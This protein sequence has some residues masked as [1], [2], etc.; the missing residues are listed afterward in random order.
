VRPEQVKEDATAVFQRIHPDDIEQV[1]ASIAVSARDITRWQDDYRVV[2][3]QQGLHWRSGNARPQRLPDGSTLWHGFIEDSTA[4]KEMEQVQHRSNQLLQRSVTG[5]F[6]IISRIMDQRDP[7]TS[8]HQ[9]RAGQIARLIGQDMGLDRQ[10]QEMLELTGLV[11]DVGKI[12]V[13]TEILTKPTRLTDIELQIVQSHASAGYEIL[14]GTNLPRVI[15]DA[16]HQHHERL[17]G[18]GYPQGLKGSEITLEARIIAV[19]DVLESMSSH[20]PYRP[21][22][23]VARA[24]QELKQGRGSLY[25]AAVVDAAVKIAQE[26]LLPQEST[27]H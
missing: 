2:L 26:G 15:I 20:R 9:R 14:K 16:I 8:G 3:P 19:A 23:G 25:D 10:A 5:S 22:L 18:S 12:A 7:Y 1:M 11:H 6:E 27:F 13:P 4:R 21:A 24:L 17:D